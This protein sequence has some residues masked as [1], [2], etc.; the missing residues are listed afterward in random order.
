MPNQYGLGSQG[1][2]EA[3]QVNSLTASPWL[4]SGESNAR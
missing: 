3:P 4:F 2:K 1:K